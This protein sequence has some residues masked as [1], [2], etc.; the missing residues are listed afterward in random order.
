MNHERRGGIQVGSPRRPWRALEPVHGMIYFAPKRAMRTPRSARAPSHGYF[1]SRSAPMGPV[2]ADVVIATFF[3]FWPQLV[4]RSLTG[5]WDITTPEKVL[6]A[7]LDGAD[8]RAAARVR[9]GDRRA[10]TVGGRGDRGTAALAASEQLEGRPLFAGHA[11]LLWPEPPHLV[12]GTRSRCS[13]VPGRRPRRPAARRGALRRRSAGHPRR[14]RRSAGGG[15]P[16][17]PGVAEADWDAA[18]ERLRRGIVGTDGQLTA[19]ARATRACRS[20]HR[21]VGC[22][23]VRGL[24]R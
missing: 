6:A 11:A 22:G 15:A 21:R 9:S 14:H 5:V 2:P 1:A 13:R 17:E 3:N 7:R 23:R 18:V 10:G 8:R 20:A 24:E 4:R 16:G 12:S 19:E